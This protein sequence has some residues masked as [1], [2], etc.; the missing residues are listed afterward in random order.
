M[1]VN[2]YKGEGRVRKDATRW[3][4]GEPRSNAERNTKAHCHYAAEA[5][6]SRNKGR[7]RF[8]TGRK[9]KKA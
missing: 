9:Q 7:N 5:K 1:L 8:R 6:A 4:E 3:C 2:H